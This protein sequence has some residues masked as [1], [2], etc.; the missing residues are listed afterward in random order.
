MHP[1]MTRKPPFSSLFRTKRNGPT[2]DTLYQLSVQLWL[3]RQDLKLRPP[4]YELR[5]RLLSA[6]FET[7]PGLFGQNCL[8]SAPLVPL[9]AACSNPSLGHGLGQAIE[10]R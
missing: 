3:R 10:W 2:T 1:Q 9:S 6:A 4:G 8:L 5:P 7:F